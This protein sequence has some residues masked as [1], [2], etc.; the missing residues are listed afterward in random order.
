MFIVKFFYFYYKFGISTNKVVFKFICI[1]FKFVME[2]KKFYN[3]YVSFVLFS[4][5][6][7]MR[8]LVWI[9]GS[10]ILFILYVLNFI[11]FFFVDV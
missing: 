2:M 5:Y 10:R 11:F 9:F 1:D 3:E 4:K 7:Y 6:F 8:Y